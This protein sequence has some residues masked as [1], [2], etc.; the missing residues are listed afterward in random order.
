[1]CIRDRITD[2]RWIR[3]SAGLPDYGLFEDLGRSASGKKWKRLRP[4]RRGSNLRV[5]GAC[6]DWARMR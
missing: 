3:R 6:A 4:Q 2:C 5:L 1:M